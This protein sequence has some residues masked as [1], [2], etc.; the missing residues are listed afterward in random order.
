MDRAAFG[1]APIPHCV[2]R[3]KAASS[4]NR[5]PRA[6]EPLKGFAN[7]SARELAELTGASLTTARRWRRL[8]KAPAI[9][10]R[11]LEIHETHNLGR[12]HAEWDGWSIS[13]DGKLHTPEGDW[14]RPGEVRAIRWRREQIWWLQRQVRGLRPLEEGLAV[15]SFPR[16]RR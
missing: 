11:A 8:Q 5:H 15:I 2:I 1:R 4:T 14:F 6:M 9:V 3:V 13:R 7:L 12:F 16:L 10:V